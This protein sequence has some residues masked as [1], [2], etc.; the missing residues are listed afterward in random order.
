VPRPAGAPPVGR[1][2]PPVFRSGFTDNASARAAA[3]V[4][5]KRCIDRG[6]PIVAWTGEM[7]ADVRRLVAD[8]R[9]RSAPGAVVWADQHWRVTGAGWADD[10]FALT[11]PA[12]P[13]GPPPAGGLWPAL[14][15]VPTED[16]LRLLLLGDADAPAIATYLSREGMHLFDPRAGLWWFEAGR[17]RDGFV[18]HMR[19]R[20]RGTESADVSA[21]LVGDPTRRPGE[22][23]RRWLVRARNQVFAW[24]DETAPLALAFHPETLG[25]SDGSPAS[26]LTLQMAGLFRHYRHVDRNM[27]WRFT[28]RPAA[29]SVVIADD[30]S[31]DEL[32]SSIADH[33]AGADKSN[34]RVRTLSF[35]RNTGALLGTAISPGGDG[36]VLNIVDKAAYLVGIDVDGL[37][38]HNITAHPALG[39]AISIFETEYVLVNGGAH[40]ASLAD[41]ASVTYDNPFAGRLRQLLVGKAGRLA[42]FTRAE[43]DMGHVTAEPRP[44]TARAMPPG[45]VAAILAYAQAAEASATGFWQT[46]KAPDRLRSDELFAALATRHVPAYCAAIERVTGARPQ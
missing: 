26:D 5:L 2:P 32:R 38:E 22:S 1:E 3:A 30:V 16:T 6:A 41:L 13:G 24:A 10:F 44:Q 20:H 15:G 34:R 42:E 19:R 11:A 8:Q 7:T 37:A 43:R 33:S 18:A 17:A 35:C 12:P 29:E 31:Y 4:W 40:P 23:A 36:H 46:I 28:S 45:L 25:I 9:F 14:H 39:R 21:Y 27:I